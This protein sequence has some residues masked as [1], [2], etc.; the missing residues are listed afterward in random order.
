[1]ARVVP[2]RDRRSIA[3]RPES[4]SSPASSRS[5]TWPR[6]YRGRHLPSCACV[7]VTTDDGLLDRMKASTGVC[8]VQLREAVDPADAMLGLAR[9]RR[10]IFGIPHPEEPSDPLPSYASEVVDTGGGPQF[11]FD[12]ADAEAYEGLVER[13][14]DV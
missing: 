1:M 2:G 6:S 13:I 5:S 10:A 12:V 11:C 9:A 3:S 4:G 7:S 14:L 8:R